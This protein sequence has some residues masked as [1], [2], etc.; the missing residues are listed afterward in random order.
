M[1]GTEDSDLNEVYE[2]LF[3][4]RTFRYQ[5]LVGSLII[6]FVFGYLNVKDYCTDKVLEWRN[7]GQ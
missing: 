1:E 7:Q 6:C 2:D 3:P 4:P 5:R